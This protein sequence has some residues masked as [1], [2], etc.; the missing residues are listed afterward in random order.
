MAFR[1]VNTLLWSELRHTGT[2]REIVLWLMTGPQRTALPG[3]VAIG[4][5]GMAEAMHLPPRTVSK[6]LDELA[7]AGLV[8]VDV[9]A[10]L[11]RLVPA[12]RWDSP[13]NAKVLE[14]WARLLRDLPPSPLIARHIPSLREAAAQKCPTDATEATFAG[15][16]TETDNDSGEVDRP[17]DSL[18]VASGCPPRARAR[19]SG[20]GL[21]ASASASAEGSRAW[22]R[23]PSTWA[24]NE[25]H[26][27]IARKR[28]VDFETELASFRDYD[29]D[30]PKRDPDATFRNWLRRARPMN[31]AS[32]REP[33]KQGDASDLARLNAV[34]AAL[35]ERP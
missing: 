12:P 9:D 27:E 25:E 30:K 34:N 17:P 33:P 23:V 16:E 22:R 26:R 24:P 20:L 6:A 35:R 32:R 19:S 11:V 10:P 1:M 13:P 14:A 28:K 18:P 21:R 4:P 31:G 7:S 5:A 29:F 15:Y 3:L 2:A 8:E